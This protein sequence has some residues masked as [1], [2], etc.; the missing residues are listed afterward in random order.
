MNFISA[1]THS[2]FADFSDNVA[3]VTLIGGDLGDVLRGGSGN[4]ALNGGSG[5]DTIEGGL[6]ANRIDGGSGANTLSYANVGITN[7]RLAY[8]VVVDLADGFAYNWGRSLDDAIANV[9]NIVGTSIKDYLYGNAAANVFEGGAGADNIDGR[10]GN[11]TVSYEHSGAGV[12]VSLATGFGTGRSGDDGGDYILNVENLT[13]S[14]YADSLTGDAGAN[15]LYGYAGADTLAG[16][17]GAD[18]YIVR[19][20]RASVVEAEGQGTDRV[21]AAVNYTLTDNVENLT[22][23]SNAI[24]GTGNALANVIT[25]S[26]KANVIDGKGGLDVLYGKG[27]DDTFAFSTAL[28]AGNVDRIVDFDS[29]D[30]IR[31]DSTIFSQLSAGDLPDDVFKNLDLGRQDANDKILYDQDTGRLFY[32]ADGKG[33]EAAKLFALIGNHADLDASDFRIV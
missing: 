32:D 5:N 24:D 19:D 28:G 33:G 27:G 30:T 13:G 7:P 23:I 17:D 26:A 11:D 9:Q 22:L 12:I 15:R 6:G 4:D 25:G 18:T 31:L 1:H 21:E 3:S 8:G 29:T 2:I 14:R 20:V 10:G 16:G